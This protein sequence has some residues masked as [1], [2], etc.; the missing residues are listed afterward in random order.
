MH[1]P[2]LYV[3]IIS[4]ARHPHISPPHTSHITSSHLTYHLLIPHI[5]PPHTSHIT[6]SHLTYHLL[7]PH[8]PPHVSPTSPSYNVS[9]TV[10]FTTTSHTSSQLTFSTLTPTTLHTSSPSSPSSPQ[11][12]YQE[13]GR[14]AQM[15]ERLLASDAHY[16]TEVIRTKNTDLQNK[17]EQFSEQVDARASLLGLSVSFHHQ[18]DEVSTSFPPS[19][20]PLFPLPSSASPLLPPLLLTSLL[21]LPPSSLPPSLT[22]SLPSLLSSHISHM[23]C[24]HSKVFD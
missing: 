21:H 13:V 2:H 8:I 16:A 4:R 22:H 7:T 11:L 9:S 19:P 15:G 23:V 10:T 18:Q 3:C 24:L 1:D 6:S 17:W 12:K 20:T 14:V 5:S